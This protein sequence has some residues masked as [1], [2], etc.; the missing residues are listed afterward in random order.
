MAKEHWGSS[1]VY[2]LNI[3]GRSELCSYNQEFFKPVSL[4]PPGSNIVKKELKQEA[5]EAH[6]VVIKEMFWLK[7]E[8]C[9]H[10]RSRAKTFSGPESLTAPKARVPL[11]HV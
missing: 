4:L 9:T 6:L 3:Q 2:P 1:V 8:T 5:M 7:A 10:T 11:C